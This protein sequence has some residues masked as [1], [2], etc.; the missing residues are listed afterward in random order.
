MSLLEVFMI[1]ESAYA[2]QN[3]FDAFKHQCFGQNGSHLTFAQFV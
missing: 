1:Q 3:V 2:R